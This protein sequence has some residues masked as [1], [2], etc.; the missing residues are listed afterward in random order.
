MHNYRDT[1]HCVIGFSPFSWRDVRGPLEFLKNSW[2]EG[3]EED[4]TIGEWLLS[5]RAKM[6]KMAEIVSDREAKAKQTMK[7]FYDRSA[8]SKTFAVGDMVLVRKPVLHGKL[9]GA[10][11]GPYQ[12]EE[13]VS[14]VTYSI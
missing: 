13:K 8:S 4:S 5:V 12:V 11:D 1:P 9:G 6:C 10:W 3:S 7:R 14:P 2:I